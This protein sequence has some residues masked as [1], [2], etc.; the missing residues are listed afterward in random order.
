MPKFSN[1]K[2]VSTYC[3]SSLFVTNDNKV[4][5]F[6]NNKK[7]RIGL[8]PVEKVFEPTIITGLNNIDQINCG[9]FHTL[10]LDTSGTAFS[11]GNGHCG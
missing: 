9:S 4:Y 8:G 6:G 2:V 10:A 3:N 7:G 11:T 5:G 1:I